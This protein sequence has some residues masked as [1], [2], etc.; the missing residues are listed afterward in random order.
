MEIKYIKRQ[1]DGLKL[2]VVDNSEHSHF[3]KGSILFYH[4]VDYETEHVALVTGHDHENAVKITHAV[5]SQKS[6]SIVKETFLPAVLNGG[7]MSYTVVKLPEST[8]SHNL[9]LKI[10]GV[11]AEQKIK[12]NSTKSSKL[13]QRMHHLKTNLNG[14]QEEIIKQQKFHSHRFFYKPFK[15]EPRETAAI[16]RSIAKTVFYQNK[17][18]P[19]TKKGCNCVAF[20]ALILQMHDLIRGR[21]TDN[22]V[23]KD[24]VLNLSRKHG[25]NPNRHEKYAPILATH[26]DSHKLL[27]NN[28]IDNDFIQFD[29][30]GIYLDP[31]TMLR[32]FIDPDSRAS[33]SPDNRAERRCEI[34]YFI[35][36]QSNAQIG[37][38]LGFGS[39]V[40]GEQDYMEYLKSIFKPDEDDDFNIELEPDFPY[41]DHDP[42][43]NGIMHHV[44]SK[45]FREQV[46][47]AELTTLQSSV[48]LPRKR[49]RED[50][51]EPDGPYQVMPG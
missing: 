38:Y 42:I 48:L 39:G 47:D 41:Q 8:W 12:F 40:H 49:P 9:L 6:E 20:I 16:Y 24:I 33:R 10:A 44:V 21:H 51:D 45:A 30:N 50:D 26:Y 1:R 27:I 28:M 37:R 36:G 15:N 3:P 7:V 34:S 17:K 5:A 43:S 4:S 2:D 46:F 32:I 14:D 23:S 22:I 18:G 35:S 13:K 29:H 25:I 31:G 19:I 11:F